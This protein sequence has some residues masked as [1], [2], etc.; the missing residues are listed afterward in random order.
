MRSSA[1]EIFKL[2]KE[3]KRGFFEVRII[4][5]KGKLMSP[6]GLRFSTS[7]WET[8]LL[9]SVIISTDVEDKSE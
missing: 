2:T 6:E 4:K 3:R 1:L 5:K 8:V 9:C 7:W